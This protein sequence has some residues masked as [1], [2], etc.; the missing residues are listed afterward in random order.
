MIDIVIVTKNAAEYLEPCLQA[1]ASFEH[2]HIV[3]S[4]STDDTV[5]IAKK[6]TAHIHHYV[7]DGKYPKKRQWCLANVQFKTDW[8]LFLD[9]DEIL[10]QALENEICALFKT[11]PQH[12]G[13]FIQGQYIWNGAALKHGLRNSKLCLLNRH[14]FEFPTLND[15]SCPAMGEIE[16]HYQPVLKSGFA[17]SSIEFL[18]APILHDA[19]RNSAAWEERHHRYATWEVY[20][21]THGLWPDE[22]TGWR[23]TLKSTFR[24]K[25]T[26]PFRPI[27]AFVHSYIL[28]L[29]FADGQ[30]GYDFARSRAT[31]YTMINR[32]AKTD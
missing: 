26:R 1:L 6:H 27:I 28:K 25:F 15:L 3:D 17:D 20:M 9:A 13:Y 32:A 23:R 24:S 21:D 22:P 8:V 12:S 16:G 29:G 2:I 4:D 7:W 11:Q 14:H 18:N 10:T 30:A 31:Y 5:S 19:Y